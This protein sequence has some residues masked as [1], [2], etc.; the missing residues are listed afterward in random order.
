MSHAESFHSSDAEK[1]V[2]NHVIDTV[3]F[4]L[5]EKDRVSSWYLNVAKE[6][7]RFHLKPDE[8]EQLIIVIEQ[9]CM[10]KIAI[11]EKVE[12]ALRG[13]VVGPHEYLKN[14]G[15]IEGHVLGAVRNRKVPPAPNY[16]KAELLDEMIASLAV[17]QKVLSAY[18]QGSLQK[19]RYDSVGGVFVGVRKF[20][21]RRQEDMDTQVDFGGRFFDGETDDIGIAFTNT[22]FIKIFDSVHTYSDARDRYFPIWEKGDYAPPKRELTPKCVQR[23]NRLRGRRNPNT[24]Y[25][26]MAKAHLTY[27]LLAHQIL[28]R[29]EEFYRK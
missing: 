27:L 7:E 22:Q 23:V 19:E 18:I 10:G 6:I 17:T 26:E 25:T 28:T 4:R 11:L 14:P 3:N 12:V 21:H 16:D 20:N 8:R 5:D 24:V 9:A 29:C 2:S 1:R 15:E 13:D